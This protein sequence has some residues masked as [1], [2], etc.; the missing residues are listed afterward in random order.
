M[1]KEQVDQLV[2][3]YKRLLWLSKKLSV[4]LS[5][6]SARVVEIERLLTE[7]PCYPDDLMFKWLRERPEE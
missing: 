5:K 1:N 2:H 3:E 4:R 7:G 6:V